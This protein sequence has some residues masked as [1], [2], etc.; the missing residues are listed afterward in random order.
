MN[1]QLQTLLIWAQLLYNLDETYSLNFILN[2]LEFP[3][4][5]DLVN[6]CIDKKEKFGIIIS[7]KI[8]FDVDSNFVSKDF[9]DI[10]NFK[11]VYKALVDGKILII[12]FNQIKEVINE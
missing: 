1:I 2:G 8:V 5:G 4:K 3:K 12:N 9:K 11:I 6:L 7:D 10:K